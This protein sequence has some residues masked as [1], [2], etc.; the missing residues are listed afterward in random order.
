MSA[1]YQRPPKGSATLLILALG[2][3]GCAAAGQQ[4]FALPT[5]YEVHV[6]TD[7]G[8]DA[9]ATA[10]AAL[11]E[12]ESRVAVEFRIVMTDDACPG[13]STSQGLESCFEIVPQSG[14]AVVQDCGGDDEVVGCTYVTGGVVHIAA[15]DSPGAP[16]QSH[17]LL[18][19]MGHALGLQHVQNPTALMYPTLDGAAHVESLDIQQYEALRR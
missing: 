6:S 8:P 17:V 13:G 5:S 12:W 2:S 18:H 15:D 7:F 4:H 19:E 11:S 14:L 9:T 3:G 10:L 1:T 16:D